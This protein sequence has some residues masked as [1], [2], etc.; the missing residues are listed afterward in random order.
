MA[1]PLIS[2]VIPLHNRAALISDALD[3][4]AVQSYRPLEI[5]VVD[6]G[7][8]DDSVQV[9]NAWAARH[10]SQAGLNVMLVEQPNQGAN[11]ARN[12]GIDLATGEFVAFLDSDDRWQPEKLAEQIRQLTDNPTAAGVYCGLTT[13]DLTTDHPLPGSGLQAMPSGELLRDLLVHDVTSPTSCW[14]VRS[15]AIRAAGKFDTTLPARQDWDMWI[16]LAQQ[17]P[18][19]ALPE[20]LVAMGEHTGDRVRSDPMRELTAHRL[21]H[22]KYRTLRRTQPLWVSLAAT[23]AM[24]RRRGRVYHHHLHRHTAAAGYL[25]LAIIIWPLSF[26]SYA[27]L[28]GILLPTR[29]RHY[30]HLWNRLFGTTPLAIRSH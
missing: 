13:V 20:P 24:Y 30:L 9:V 17:G 21:I 16:R 29:P 2:T 10:E 28:L 6:D 14:M 23:A 7:S 5:I 18:I 22:A 3:S 4:V 19:T 15:E 25:L 26:D 1:T 27:A 11:A 8:T 12:R